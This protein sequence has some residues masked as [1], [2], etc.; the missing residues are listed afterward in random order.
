MGGVVQCQSSQCPPG[1][2]CKDNEDGNS[3]CAK[4][5]KGAVGEGEVWV[6]MAG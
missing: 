5:S 3:N 2:Y 6:L 4:I 1:T